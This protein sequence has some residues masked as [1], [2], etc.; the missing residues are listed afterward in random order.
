MVEGAR[1]ESVYTLVAYRGFESLRLRQIKFFLKQISELDMH[2]IPP[3]FIINLKRQPDRREKMSRL[4]DKYGL[5]YEFVEG[6][7]GTVIPDETFN[8]LYND[9]VRKNAGWADFPMQK[10]TVAAYL[11]HVNLFERMIK[12]NIAEAIIFEDDVE[13]SDDFVEIIKRQDQL[14]KNYELIYFDHDKAKSYPKFKK[15]YKDYKCVRYRRMSKHSKRTIIYC[16]AYQLSRAGAIKLFSH[17]FPIVMPIDYMM[18]H[19]NINKLR[20]YGIE[21]LCC[22]QNQ[23]DNPSVHYL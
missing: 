20:C 10:T 17:A 2:S 1:L 9:T 18:G 11:A 8:F 4:F 21:P 22:R 5:S 14:P 16:G 15:I 6:V 19:L 3:I 12:E 23:R 13:F 7:D